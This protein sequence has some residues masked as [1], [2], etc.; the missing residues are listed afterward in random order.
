M[1]QIK[2][3]KDDNGNQFYPRT[4]ERAVLDENGNSLESKMASIQ[5]SIGN[6]ATSKEDLTNLFPVTTA[7]SALTTEVGKYYRL[8]VPVGT[9]VVTLPSMTDLTTVRTVVIYLTG[10]T[11]PAVTISA[12]DSKDV[13][14]QDGFGLEAG[15]TYEVNALFNGSAWVV[16]S[17]EIVIPTNEGE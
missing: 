8:D 12:A 2:Q 10:G 17:V 1:V 16:A 4:S 14:Y 15:K 7:V 3:L 9:L 11:T 6:L 5:Q 13:Y